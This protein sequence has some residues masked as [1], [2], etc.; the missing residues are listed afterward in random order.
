MGPV[1]AFVAEGLAQVAQPSKRRIVMRLELRP[2]LRE[3]RVG[4]RRQHSAQ[5]VGERHDPA[6][7]VRVHHDAELRA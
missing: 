3:L 1:G 6:H 7:A 5:D 4:A 2:P